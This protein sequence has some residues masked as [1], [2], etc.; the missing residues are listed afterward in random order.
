MN[1]IR[2]HNA[3][4]GGNPVLVNLEQVT[5]ITPTAPIASESGATIFFNADV[6]GLRLN[7]SE[8]FD[9]PANTLVPATVVKRT[10]GKES[11]VNR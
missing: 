1:F 4:C 5:E 7:T 3:D 6:D 9:E 8:S 2:V 10:L 11:E